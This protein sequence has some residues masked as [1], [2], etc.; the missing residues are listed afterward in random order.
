MEIAAD[1]V[2]GVTAVAAGQT[3]SLALIT[4]GKVFACGD[5]A[6]GQLDVPAEA[7]SNIVAIA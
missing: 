3:H 5:N 1:Q 2:R 6:N 4:S 7:T